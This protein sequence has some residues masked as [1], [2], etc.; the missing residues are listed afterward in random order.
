MHH[1]LTSAGHCL[2]LIPAPTDGVVYRCFQRLMQRWSAHVTGQALLIEGN[3]PLTPNFDAAEPRGAIARLLDA[4]LDV[5]GRIE[6]C[7]GSLRVSYVRSGGHG[8]RLYRQSYFDEV[9]LEID[10]ATSVTREQIGEM[11]LE[12]TARLHAS[13]ATGTAELTEL[14][15]AL[16]LQVRSVEAERRT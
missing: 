8:P 6:L 12:I 10:G 7:F 5:I 3:V 9:R 13:A 15:E 16:P 1:E 11:L 14:T 4:N 2:L